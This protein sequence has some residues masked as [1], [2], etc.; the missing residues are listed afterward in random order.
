MAKKNQSNVKNMKKYMKGDGFGGKKNEC[1]FGRI[2]QHFFGR[3]CLWIRSAIIYCIADKSLK[4]SAVHFID[5][6]AVSMT[7]TC[8]HNG[9]PPLVG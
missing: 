1:Q 7:Q 9:H 3:L 8:S 5:L 4:Q 6:R 2:N